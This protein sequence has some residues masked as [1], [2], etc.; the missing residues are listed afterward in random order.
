[1]S[2]NNPEFR[3]LLQNVGEVHI[4]PQIDYDEELENVIRYIAEKKT[5]SLRLL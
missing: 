5:C 3:L 2:E 4:S 1:M